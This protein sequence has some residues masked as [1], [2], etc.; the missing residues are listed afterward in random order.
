MSWTG[1]MFCEVDGHTGLHEAK[2]NSVAFHALGLLIF[3]IPLNIHSN[4]VVD[5]SNIP[6]MFGTMGMLLEVT[7]EFPYQTLLPLSIPT[8]ISVKAQVTARTY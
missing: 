2:P 4:F 1:W 3:S 5:C 7:G 6:R 8:I